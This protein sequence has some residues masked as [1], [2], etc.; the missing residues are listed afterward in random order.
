MQSIGRIVGGLTLAASL[1]C[2]AAGPASAAPWS[3]LLHH[4]AKKAPPTPDEGIWTLP[5][6]ASRQ[7]YVNEGKAA[8]QV[9]AYVC[10]DAKA[11]E[12]PMVEVVLTGRAPVEAPV[13]C[14]SV[15]LVVDSGEKVT[16]VNPGPAGVSGSYKIA[17]Q[18]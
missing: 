4:G 9:V 14:R 13:G 15:Y 5:G 17:K 1:V 8:V 18:G 11:T 2:I 7:I 12:H 10:V 3:G 6:A 16:L